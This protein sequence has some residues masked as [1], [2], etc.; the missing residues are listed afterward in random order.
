MS[1]ILQFIGSSPKVLNLWLLKSHSSF[2]DF[3][4]TIFSLVM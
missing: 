1:K 4:S 3:K 2:R